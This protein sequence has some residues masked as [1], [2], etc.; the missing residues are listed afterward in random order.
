[1]EVKAT[2]GGGGVDTHGARRAWLCVFRWNMDSETEPV[3]ERRHTRVVEVMLAEL[4]TDDFRR[5]PRGE[6]G[7]RTASPNRDGLRKLR[8]NRVY[9]E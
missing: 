4:D 3:I 7:T 1:M 6:L 9:R 8:N 2:K 5:N